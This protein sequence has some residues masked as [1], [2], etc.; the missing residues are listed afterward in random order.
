MTKIS[1]FVTIFV[2]DIMFQTLF[3]TEPG[4]V[5][6]ITFIKILLNFIRF[7][8][9]IGLIV[10]IILD[11]YKNMING[12]DEKE[13]VI[14]KS[15]NRILAC[16]IVFCLPMIVNIIM[17]LISKTGVT[18]NKYDENFAT[19]YTEASFE[20]ANKLEEDKKLK[21]EEE[22]EVIRKENLTL[23]AKYKA[24]EL[25]IIEENKKNNGSSAEYNSNLTDLN[26]QNK[27]YIENGVFYAP[28]YVSGNESTY[29]GKECPSNPLQEGYNNEYGYNNHFWSMLESLIQGAK[30]AGYNLTPSTQGCRSY[31]T[32]YNFYHKTYKN[33]PGRAARPGRS[34]HGWGIASDL[35][36][37]KD[38]DTTCG[39]VRTRSN[40]PGMA[41]VHDNAEKYGLEFPLNN[42][43]A[44]YKEDWHIQ[45]INL[46]RY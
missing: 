1:Q 42:D 8:L 10:M 7:L 16:V 30:D 9:P 33:Q 11:F 35:T 32:Q 19:C 44:S 29:S 15:G 6:V 39:N 31:T 24:E 36:F 5:R 2:G 37:Y 27:V 43:S 28:K 17:A 23:A 41:W 22:Q 34:L 20:L 13:S 14:K 45:P 25:A 3:C 46:K 21:L 26:K 12:I 4:I 18:D 40:C 38:S